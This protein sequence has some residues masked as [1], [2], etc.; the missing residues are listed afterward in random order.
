MYPIDQREEQCLRKPFRIGK[1]DEFELTYTHAY[2]YMVCA[3]LIALFLGRL[4]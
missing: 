2:I 3:S 1:I 4:I